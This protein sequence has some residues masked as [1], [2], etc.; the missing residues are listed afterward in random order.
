MSQI[1]T[2]LD[3]LAEQKKRRS[4]SMLSA[5]GSSAGTAPDL[6]SIPDICRRGDR[7]IKRDMEKGIGEQILKL[8][9]DLARSIEDA[10]S[11]LRAEFE[12][13][14]Q[15]EILR[16]TATVEQSL[17]RRAAKTAYCNY[18]FD[19]V[20]MQAITSNTNALRELRTDAKSLLEDF[21]GDRDHVDSQFTK[22][23]LRLT[24]PETQD[25]MD[26]S[27]RTRNLLLS[28]KTHIIQEDTRQ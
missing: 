17:S 1:S 18:R 25:S 15:E 16:I 5:S 4:H 23:A 28:K 8:R 2:L 6:S 24:I 21:R 14:L 19:P 9:A 3:E 13:R 27:Y 10:L 7:A 20:T 26:Q 22:V 12:E 11:R